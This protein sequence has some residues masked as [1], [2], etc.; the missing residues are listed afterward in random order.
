[1]GKSLII[2]ESPA[3]VKTIKKFLGPGYLVQASVGHIRD[4]PKSNIGVDEANDFAPEYE[5]IQGK[6]KVVQSLRDAASKVDTVFLAPDPDREGEAIAWHVAELLKD[7][8]PNIKRIQ[9]NEITSRAV[10]EALDHPR[11]LNVN[12]FDAQQARRVLDRLVGYKIS[13]L[14]W[15]NVKRGI[16]AGRVQSVALRLIVEREE[17]RQA[18]VPEEYWLF[19]AILEGSI[20]PPFKAELWKVEGKKPVIP[21]AETADALEKAMKGA[22]FTVSAIEEKERSRAPMPPFI[23]ST[24]QQAANQRLSYPA[25]RTMN[26]AQRLYEGLELGDRGTVALITYMRTDSVRIADEAQKAAAD[27][28]EN[29]FGKDYLAPGGKRNFKTKSDAQDAHEAIRPVD[30][31]LT[32]EDVKPYLAPD[33][34]QVYRLIWARFVASQMAAARFHDT[35]VT[36]DNGPVQ[37]RSKGER[38]LFPGFL[39]VMPRGKDEEGVEL[40][41]LT[42]GETLKLNSLTK[43]QK[44]T[45]PSPRFTE[46]SLVR[47]LEE[48]GIGRP[49]TYASIISTLQDR[50]YVTLEEKHF[51]PTDLG[52]VVCDRLREHFKTLMDVGFTAHM[53]E[54][55]DKVA[56][57]QQDW[58][59]LL[60]NFNNDFDPT[61]LEAAKSMGKAKTDTVTDIPCPECAAG[62]EVR[63]NRAVSRVYRLPRVPVYLELHPRRA[64]ADPSS[65]KGQA[66]VRK[67]RDLPRM[68]QGSRAQAFPHRQPVHCLF[69]ISGL[70]ARRTLFHRRPLP[71][72]RLQRRACGKKFQARQDILLVQQLSPVRLCPVGLAHR[73]ALPRMRLSAAGDEKYQ[74]QGQV[75][76]L[77]RKDLQI[78]APP[79]R[80]QRGRRGIVSV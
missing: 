71:P 64:R 24:L 2:V 77:P 72:R 39:A 56:E 76:R 1:M 14:L 68:R 18:F 23:T 21:N 66:G 45:Q 30:V 11:D 6:E 34:Y 80:R 38:M 17:E 36:I 51:A 25:K 8:N 33:Q 79:R 43:E 78:H 7:K 67:G 54:L 9:F 19:K 32:P 10:H 62:R 58:V 52:R 50:D 29:R 65:G 61:L 3:K 69:G 27:F 37:W 47:E 49:S 26:I 75:H 44:F 13:P 40:P 4:L 73:R 55:L 31:T 20:P 59:A 70:Q 48:L 16:S 5:I 22:P 57:G 74:G 60:R 35:T 15:K 41:A 53:E 28:I 46:S 12:L 42:K 63:Q